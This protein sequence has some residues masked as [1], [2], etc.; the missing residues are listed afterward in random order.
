M[1]VWMWA[2][3][4]ARGMYGWHSGGRSA[5]R[6]RESYSC[7]QVVKRFDAGGED[8]KVNEGVRVSRRCR[9]VALS[10]RCGDAPVE[11][12]ES[13]QRTTNAYPR[14]APSAKVVSARCTCSALATIAMPTRPRYA[15]LTFHPLSSSMMLRAVDWRCQ[16]GSGNHLCAQ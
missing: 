4:H 3:L 7:G 13:E 9:W 8:V 11:Q 12:P 1:S 15:A 16:A 5:G 14:C 2:A 6:L 10:G